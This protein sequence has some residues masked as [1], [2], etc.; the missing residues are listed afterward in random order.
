MATNQ[1]PLTSEL[2]LVM[3]NGLGGSGQQLSIN[4]T[5][6]NVKCS[7]SDDDVYAIAQDIISLQERNVLAIQRRDTIEIQ[8]A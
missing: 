7:A 5:Y 1:V 8:E 6:K 4:R 3:D 2:I